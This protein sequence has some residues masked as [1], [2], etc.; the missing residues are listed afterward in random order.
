[1]KLVSVWSAGARTAV[2]WLVPVLV[3]LLL[4]VLVAAAV[5][6]SVAGAHIGLHRKA[7]VASVAA[8]ANC[9]TYKN[10]WFAGYSGTVGQGASEGAYA[11]ITRRVGAACGSDHS[12]T[13]NAVSTWALIGSGSNNGGY[14]QSGTQA[15][16][17]QCLTYFA[18][19]HRSNSYTPQTKYGGC[20]SADGSRHGYSQQYG[21]GCHCEYAKIDGTVWM[22]T[23]WDP[24]ANWGYP[25]TP[26]FF[27]EANYRESDVPGSAAAPTDFASL[28]GQNGSDNNFHGL[29]CNGF[30]THINDGA[31]TRSDGNAWYDRTTSCPS[32][33]IYTDV[34]G[35]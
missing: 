18:Q 17:G 23:S 3:S 22:T 14:V 12:Q 6:P 2:S 33:N 8:L 31:A 10:S 32:F 29:T 28:Q 9:G 1:M 11:T 4:V 16:Y 19:T 13:H 26:Q 25:F 34:A 27:G 5:M 30:L 24:Y 7:P 21:A 35:H 15:G 20:I